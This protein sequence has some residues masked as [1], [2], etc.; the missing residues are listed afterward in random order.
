MGPVRFMCLVAP[1]RRLGL[2]GVIDPTVRRPVGRRVRRTSADVPR[3]EDVI[4]PARMDH[5][6]EFGQFSHGSRLERGGHFRLDF[7][8]EILLKSLNPGFVGVRE[9]VPQVR[10]VS[11]TSMWTG[12]TLRAAARMNHPT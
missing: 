2:E 3:A 4:A 5:A 7:F 6:F 11:P 12:V 9:P 8:P 1:I 10:M